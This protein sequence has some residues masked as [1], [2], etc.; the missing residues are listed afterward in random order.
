MN[1]SQGWV[2][3][4]RQFLEWE[5]FDD[6][7]VF[8]LF[9]YCLL[10][11]NHNDNK[12]RGQVVKRGTFLTSLE[13]LSKDT[14]LSVRSV[15]T[16]L[17]KLESTGELTS[18]RNAKGTI[19]QV[20][21]YDC[22]QLATSETTNERQASDK[23]VTTNKNDKKE[24]NEKNKRVF[25]SQDYFIRWFNDRKGKHTGVEGKTKLLNK[26][27]ENNFKK[28]NESYELQDFETA[29]SNLFKNE[30]AIN[31]NGLNPAHFL[32]IDNFTRYLN[33]E[34]KKLNIYEQHK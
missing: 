11:A 6:A 27:S 3:L 4:H 25:P 22:Y 31:N 23:Q 1:N 26:A 29:I 13:L 2:R 15:R 34:Q 10:K 30:W 5:W 14:G 9:I 19:I 16:S 20:V 21:K 8:R 12:Y 17:N 32:R 33:T 18:K 28:L 7:N 24:K